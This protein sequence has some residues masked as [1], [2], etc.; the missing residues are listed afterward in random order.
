LCYALQN[1]TQI[2]RSSRLCEALLVN[3]LVV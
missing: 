2:M 1:I 3:V